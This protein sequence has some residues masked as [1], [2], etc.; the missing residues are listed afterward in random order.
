MRNEKIV[1]SWDKLNPGEIE[2]KRILNKIEEKQGIRSPK[3][4]PALSVAVA[5]VLCLAI[6]GGIFLSPKG[7]NVFNLTAYALEAREDGST[8]LREIDIADQPDTYWNGYFNDGVFYVSVGLKCEGE[9]LK[10]VEFSVDEGFFAKQYI[11][12]AATGT[13]I[14]AMYVNDRL[15]MYGTEFEKLGNKFTLTGDTLGGELLL[16]WGIELENVAEDS[17]FDRDSLPEKIDIRATAR[18]SDGKTQEETLTIDLPGPGAWGGFR[19]SDEEIARSQRRTDYYDSLPLEDLELIPESVQTVT[20]FYWYETED[21]DAKM[22]INTD[23]MVF[24]DNGF[25]RSASESDDSVIIITFQ[26]N[27]DGTVTG[28]QYR[29]PLWVDNE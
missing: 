2:K 29:A 20:G 23:V 15:V 14:P 27:A 26:R 28:T 17:I 11:G 10:S 19:L 21:G 8:E 1:D 9:N 7:N 18:F 13:D 25:T 22:G 4:R 5:A 12:G 6:I 3:R 16:F 24:D